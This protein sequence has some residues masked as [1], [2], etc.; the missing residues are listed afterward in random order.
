MFRCEG[1]YGEI[2]E[3]NSI[4]LKHGL[5]AAITVCLKDSHKALVDEENRLIPDV[6]GLELELVEGGVL[7]TWDYSLLFPTEIECRT[8]DGDWV[9]LPLITPTVGEV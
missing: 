8:D 7:V 3:S 5:V 1:K 4:I 9:A 6:T 2:V